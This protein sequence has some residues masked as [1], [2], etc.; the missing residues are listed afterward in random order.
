[1]SGFSITPS[2]PLADLNPSYVDPSPVPHVGMSGQ[3]L[4]STGAPAGKKKSLQ[5]SGFGIQPVDT[6]QMDFL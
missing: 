4:F 5:K 2:T 3:A 1:M 6:A